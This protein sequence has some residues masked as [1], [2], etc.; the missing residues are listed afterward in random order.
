MLYKRIFFIL[1]LLLLLCER[2]PN[3]FITRQKINQTFSFVSS[4]FF[5]IRRGLY[6]Y[7]F[8]TLH[9]LIQNKVLRLVMLPRVLNLHVSID[10]HLEKVL[11]GCIFEGL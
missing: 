7:T 4:M 10:L 5:P 6:I 1:L 2:P 8:V 3:Y 9:I 11:L